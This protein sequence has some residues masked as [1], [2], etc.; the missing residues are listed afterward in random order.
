[1]I[2]LGDVNGDGRID[3]LDL[4]LIQAHMLGFFSLTGDNLIAADTNKDGKISVVDLATIKIHIL[5]IR[6]LNEVIE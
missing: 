6:I 2:I 3:N 5:G 1:M 4:K